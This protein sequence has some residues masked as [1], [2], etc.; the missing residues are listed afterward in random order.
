MCRVLHFDH[1]VPYSTGVSHPCTFVIST[2]E[3]ARSRQNCQDVTQ[4]RPN[5][6][7]NRLTTHLDRVICFGIMPLLLACLLL[8]P[9]KRGENISVSM[10]AAL[11]VL[12]YYP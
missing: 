5:S 1:V 3:C 12:E 9:G 2:F 4:E 7:S 11:H 8:S 6:W 10:V